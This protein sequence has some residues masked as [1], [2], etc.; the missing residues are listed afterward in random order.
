VLL[1]EDLADNQR[2]ITHYLERAGAQLE[3]AQDGQEGVDKALAGD[4]QVVLMDMQMPKLD[5][6]TATRLLREQG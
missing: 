3:L 1:V 6:Y 5:G 4:F 2:L